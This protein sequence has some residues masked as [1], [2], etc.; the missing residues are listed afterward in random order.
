[1]ET[2]NTL[3]R[4]WDIE[5]LVEHFTLLPQD[6][7]LLANKT[8]PTRLG[9]AVLLKYFQYEARFP[10]AKQDVPKALVT[11]LANQ[12]NLSPELY[13]TSPR[14][15]EVFPRI[16]QRGRWSFISSGFQ[17]PLRPRWAWPRH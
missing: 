15:W 5:E 11:Y 14:P 4:T 7:D 17:P 6:M 10:A 12:L 2:R 16:A 13:E 8:G 9:F 3:K 1:M